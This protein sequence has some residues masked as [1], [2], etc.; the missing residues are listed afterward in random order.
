M[1]IAIFIGNKQENDTQVWQIKAG[2]KRLWITLK[3]DLAELVS[4]WKHACGQVVYTSLGSRNCQ[5][6]SAYDVE[7]QD[8]DSE[9]YKKRKL[10]WKRKLKTH[11]N[12][13]KWFDWLLP[14]N[15]VT[16]TDN[17]YILQ[18]GPW[19]DSVWNS[20]RWSL[21]L[22]SRHLVS[23]YVNALSFLFSSTSLCVLLFLV[24]FTLQQSTNFIL[25]TFNSII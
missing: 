11:V 18:D 16:D 21:W 8:D 25:L 2:V 7:N 1:C 19:G 3:T 10:Y 12:A 17:Y 24:F 9:S 5:I 13:L 6:H 22:Q 20:E 14:L 4:S 23:R 15:N